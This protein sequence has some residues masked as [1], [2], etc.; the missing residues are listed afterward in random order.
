MRVK[1]ILPSGGGTSH[2]VAMATKPKGTRTIV[3]DSRT[4]KILP[5][6]AAKQRPAT[7]ETET[8]PMREKKG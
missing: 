3:R 6:R 8:V 7:T 4:G 2:G 5:K 1:V